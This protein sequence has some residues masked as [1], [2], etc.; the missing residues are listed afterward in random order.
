MK[1]NLK[2][3]IIDGV[4]NINELRDDNGNIDFDAVME[5]SAAYPIL[6]EITRDKIQNISV[7]KNRVRK[8]LPS[9]LPTS[10]LLPFPIDEH[11]HIGEY[12]SKHT[13]YL[14]FAT[15]Y[16]TLMENYESLLKRVT[17][18]ELLNKKK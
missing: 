14:T 16:N 11:E 17:D 18:L 2:K 4:V 7:K 5:L 3:T 6:P 13:L 1:L 15:A 8:A 12:E 10:N 9:R